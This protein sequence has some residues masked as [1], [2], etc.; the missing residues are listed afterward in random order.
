MK[1]T[2]LLLCGAVLFLVTLGGF[3]TL[4]GLI[5]KNTKINEG[6]TIGKMFY[7]IFYISLK[8]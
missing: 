6:K 4:Q 8:I 5:R 1:K 2:A 3:R 7:Q